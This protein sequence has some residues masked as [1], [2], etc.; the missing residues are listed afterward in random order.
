MTELSAGARVRFGNRPAVIVFA[1]DAFL[2]VRL[3]GPNGRVGVHEFE[4]DPTA[5]RE[6][7]A[8][9]PKPKG[10]VIHLPGIGPTFLPR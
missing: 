5:V 10:R 1:E 3:I 8:G 4:T 9:D 2:K 7:L 6:P